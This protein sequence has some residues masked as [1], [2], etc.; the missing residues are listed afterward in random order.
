MPMRGIWT[1]L[2]VAALALAAI[3]VLLPVLPTTPFVI[4][5]AFAFSR[6]SPR[7]RR[8]LDDGR[9]GPAIR[10]WEERGAV[11]PRAKA[12]ACL[13][14]AGS[15]LGAALVGVPGWVLLGQAAVV[16][17]VALWLVTRPS[18]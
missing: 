11:A 5:A 12:L 1:G 14:M 6:G 10:D 17:A 2:G 3:G 15:V 4:L 8:W 13:L 9:F 7:L 18:A 16:S